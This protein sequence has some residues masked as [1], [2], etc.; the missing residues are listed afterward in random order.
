LYSSKLK[1]PNNEF[2]IHIEKSLKT[3]YPDSIKLREI[4]DPYTKYK[5]SY[6]VF[7]ELSEVNDDTTK[8]KI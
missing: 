6:M 4:N 7:I 5:Y 2:F 8:L 3:P 1:I